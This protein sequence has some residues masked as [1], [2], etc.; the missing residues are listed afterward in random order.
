M[1]RLSQIAVLVT[2]TLAALAHGASARTAVNNDGLE[3][4]VIT[5]DEMVYD[6]GSGVFTARGNVE[7]R[8][9]DRVLTAATVIYNQDAGQVVASGDV[10]V[11]DADG[12]VMHADHLELTS[13]FR[14]GIIKNVLL[15]FMDGSRLAAIDGTRSGGDR[16]TLNRAVYSPCEVCEDE[17]NPTPLWQIKARRIIHKED[18]KTIVYKHA[19]LEFFGIPVLY[20]PYLSHPDPTVNR[21]SGFLVPK[22]GSSSFLGIKTEIP[23]F[24]AIAPHRDFTFT[25]LITTRESI[26]F[27]GEYRERTKTGRYTLGGS[28]TRVDERDD[29]NLKTGA[30]EFR[31]HVAGEGRFRISDQTSWGFDGAWTSD[32]TYLRRWGISSAE[33]LTSRLFIEHSSGRNTLSAS[34]YTFQGLRIEDDAGLTPFVLPWIEHHFDSQPGWLGS[35]FSIDSSVLALTRPDGSDTQRLSVATTWELPMISRFGTVTRFIAHVRGDVYRTNGF[36]LPGG[37]DERLETDVTGRGVS[38]FAIDWRLPLVRRG[39]RWTQVIEPIVVIVASPDSGNPEAIPNEDSQSFQFDDSNIFSLNRFAGLDRWDGGSRVSYGVRYTARAPGGLAAEILGGQSYRFNG[40]T[41]LPAAAGLDERR[42]D[43]VARIKL[44]F[45]DYFEYYHRVRLDNDNFAVR[46]HEVD[47]VVGPRAIKLNLGFL[48]TDNGDLDPLNPDRREI[49]AG[50]R[51]RFSDRWSA[52]GRYIR[53]LLERQ[54]ITAEG[55][56]FYLDDCIEFGV[57]VRRNFTEDRD[58]TPSTSV[59]IRLVLKHLG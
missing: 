12:N 41:P 13:D 18:E 43:Y 44:S 38:Q 2:V 27:A 46:R 34:A 5:A 58:L 17:E 31:G 47:V 36:H 15:M 30:R 19:V 4:M 49:K 33:T 23:Y 56:L 10:R 51:V 45:A 53:N 21:R 54:D 32:D 24:F 7:I 52:S 39:R 35:H 20:L 3:P 1:S 59:I 6:R 25:P 48:E 57:T 28:V 29:D 40:R 11:T 22:V 55:G 37:P 16:N 9:R 26:S 14:D 50:A 42:S 8:Y